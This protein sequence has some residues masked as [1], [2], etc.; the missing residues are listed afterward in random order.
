MRSDFSLNHVNTA[1]FTD[2]CL[3]SSTLFPFTLQET[4]RAM[5]DDSPRRDSEEI[6][7]KSR[8]KLN[9]GGVSCRSFRPES[10]TLI[11][12]QPSRSNVFQVLVRFYGL[13]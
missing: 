8:A 1:R 9:G 13:I 2:R 6:R 7:V 3:Y 5:Y 10:A 11:A 4:K 12:N